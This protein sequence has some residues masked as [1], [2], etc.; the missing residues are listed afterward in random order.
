LCWSRALGAAPLPG[1]GTASF[2]LGDGSGAPCPCGNP[3]SPGRGCA[4]SNG[5]GAW[6]E[7]SGTTS[8]ALDDL[9]FIVSGLIPDQP[10]LLFVGHEALGGG[11]GL[12]FGDGLRCAGVSVVR[13]GVEPASQNGFAFWGPGLRAAG[14]W[15]AGDVRRF[16]AWY[17]DPLGSPCGSGF[18]LSQGVEA[19]FQP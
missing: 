17:R 5:E 7:V 16:Q 10:A 18:N 6:V 14:G 13:L 11:A 8:V 1:G 4:S 19:S 15:E 2:C 3:G 12:P 9:R